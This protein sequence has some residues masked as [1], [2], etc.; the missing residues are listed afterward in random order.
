MKRALSFIF[1]FFLI[2]SYGQEKLK[3]SLDHYKNYE[4]TS[5][6]TISPNGEQILYSRSWINLIDDKRETDLWIMN[7]NGSTNRFFLNGSN[8]KWSPDGSKIAFIKKGEPNGTQIFIKYLG[9]EGEPTQ[10]TK[11]EKSPSSMEWSPDGKFIAFLMHVSSEAALDPIGVPERP[12]GAT[13]TK[14]PQVI[15]QV[16]YSQDRVGFLERGFRQIFVVPSEGGTARQITFGE[17]DD[18]SGGISWLKDSESIVFSSYQKE[19]AEYARGQSNLYSVNINN[20]N[21]I[22]L[23]SRE[24]TESSPTVSPDGSK[25]AFVGSTWTK[26]FYHDRKMYV[27]DIDGSNLRCIT[28]SL[29]QTPSPGVWGKNSSGVYFNVREFGQS[30]VY[31]ADIK[32]KVKKITNGNHMLTMNDLVGSDAVATWTDP[33]NPSDI[34]SFSIDKPNKINRLTDVNKDIFY[35]VEFGEVEEITYKSVDEKYVQG[36]IVK[37]PNFDSNKK[38]PLVLRI[39]GGPHSMYH[40]GFNY[41][42]QLHAAQDQVVLYTNPRGSTGYGYDFANA[43]QN[44][45]PGND[46]DDIMYGV[47]EVISRGYIDENRMYVYGGSGGG[48]L[49][50]WIVGKTDR[51][52]AASV[53]YPVT[54]WFSFVGTTDGATWYYN[55]KNYPWEDPSEHIKRSPLMYVANVKTPTM[56]MCGEEDLRTPISQTEEYYQALKMNKVPTVMIRFTDEYHGTSSK[57]SNFLRTH[58]YINAWFDKHSV[59]K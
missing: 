41:N 14:G 18:I 13:W 40:V 38:Y 23:T 20:L 7:K 8:G 34:I 10:I 45:Y 58:G 48:V 33:A 11:L 5:N 37:P 53:N 1:I 19:D 49:T 54:N 31:H 55:F 6:P 28:E 3:L 42:F 35:N 59:R 26:N 30:N 2:I 17:F 36:W 56:L 57:P 25:I 15:D 22:E 24:G 9:V 4:W 43:I 21:L 46:Y 50:S 16:D 27:M 29:D 12:K 44:A 51:F 32:G 52:A 39:H 47:D